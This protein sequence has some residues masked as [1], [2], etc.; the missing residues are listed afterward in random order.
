MLSAV[1]VPLQFKYFFIQIIKS[2]LYISLT[3]WL[4]FYLLQLT[5]VILLKIINLFAVEKIRFKQYLA[6]CNWAGAPLFL[7]FP[8]SMLS[9]HMMHFEISRPLIMLILIAFFLWYNFRLGNGLRVL[10]SMRVYKI[11]VLL[12]FIYG[13][14]LFAVGAIY[15]SNYGLITYLQ[16]LMDAYP[17]F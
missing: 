12:I 17:L 3:I 15:E 1:L 6:V 16:L 2:P 5:I 14:T 10:L 8:V 9:Y 7:L 13:G 11:L 4:S